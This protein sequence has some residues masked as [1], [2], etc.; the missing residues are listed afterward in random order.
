MFSIHSGLKTEDEQ[1]EIYEGKRRRELGVEG[2]ECEG[3]G[4][5]EMGA[6]VLTRSYRTHHTGG[7][8][9]PQRI[10][11]EKNKRARA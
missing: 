2:K 8:V 4:D 9:I 11:E 3:R 1:S 7:L 6:K 10:P 5:Q